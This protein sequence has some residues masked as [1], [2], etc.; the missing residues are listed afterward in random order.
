MPSS[1]TFA[2]AALV[3]AA[4][5]GCRSAEKSPPAL[6]S[7]PP[8]QVDQYAAPSY[9]STMP[10]AT[11]STV[12]PPA[13]S[14]VSYGIPGQATPSDGPSSYDY[15]S[16]ANRPASGTSNAYG[17]SYSATP[18]SSPTYSTPTTSTYSSSYDSYSAGSS[19][20][21]KSGCCSH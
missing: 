15:G 10:P 11:A 7:S 9:P 14:N 1:R 18:Y 3:I 16:Q 5:V 8:R 4:L 13:A 19:S 2:I 20:D 17:P 6:S 21:C 12:P